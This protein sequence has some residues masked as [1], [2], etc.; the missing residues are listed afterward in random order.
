MRKTPGTP[1]LGTL[2]AKFPVRNGEKSAVRRNEWRI[3]KTFLAIGSFINK[4]QRSKFIVRI[5][6]RNSCY[7]CFLFLLN[8]PRMVET[9]KTF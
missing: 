9:L 5:R 8:K 2:R 3:A 6:I 4:I 1:E 7:F